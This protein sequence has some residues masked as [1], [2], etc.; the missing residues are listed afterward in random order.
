[1][2]DVLQAALELLAL[3]ALLAGVLFWRFRPARNEELRPR[4]RR[5]HR[6]R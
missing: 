3:S 4:P 5:P 2:R 6:R 1:M